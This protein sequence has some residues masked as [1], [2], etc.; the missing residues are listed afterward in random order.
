M[1]KT[2]LTIGFIALVGLF[3]LNFI[4]GI[5]GLMFGLLVALLGVAIKIALIGLV[6]YFIIRIIS[7]DTARRMREKFGA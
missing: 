5:F 6:L 4:F 7:P 3:A 2:I 1:L